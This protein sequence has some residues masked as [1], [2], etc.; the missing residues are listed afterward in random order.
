V[1]HLF[2]EGSQQI[3]LLKSIALALRF[4]PTRNA[5]PFDKLGLERFWLR[6]FFARTE[7]RVLFELG[8]PV[9]VWSIGR[10]GPPQSLTK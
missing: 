10:A 3:S 9:V 5:I 4:D 6:G 1:R 8:N 7:I 2:D